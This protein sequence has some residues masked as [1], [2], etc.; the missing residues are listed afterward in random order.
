M[1]MKRTTAIALL[2]GLVPASAFAAA[3]ATLRPG[4]QLAVGSPAELSITIDGDAQPPA[5]PRV[6]GASIQL[7]GQMSQTRMTN[8]QATQQM[9]YVY[10]V[11][12]TRTGPLDIPAITVTTPT[13]AESTEPVHATVTDSPVAPSQA[14]AAPAATA[15]RAV[16]LEPAHAFVTLDVPAKSLVVGQAIPIKIRAYFRGGTSATLQGL[17]HV[18]S[19]AFTLSEL[20]DKPA[21]AQ[22]EI[23]GEPYLQATW[24]AVLSPAKPSNG[25]LGVELPVELA[26][27]AAARPAQH[28]SLRDVFGADPF[29]DSFA[30]PFGGSDPFAGMGDPFG[31][32]DTMFDIG[33]MQQYQTTLRATAG[34]IVVTDLPA[35]GRPASFT[36]AVGHFDVALDPIAGEPRVGEPLTLSIRVTGTGNF[37]R[38]EMTGAADAGDLKTYSIKSAFTP[39]A[40]STLTGTKTFTQTVVPTRAGD[41]TIPALALAYFD[42]AKHA[43][44]TAETKPVTLPIAAARGGGSSD[45]GLAASVRDPAMVPNRIDAGGTRATLL[46]L[47]RQSR[48][49]MALAGLVALTALVVVA[50]WSRKSPRIANVLRSRRIDRAITRASAD[51]DRAARA[52]DRPA[53]F[54]AARTALQTRL[55]ASWDTTPEAITAHDVAT[56]L[57]DRGASIC[58][59]FEQADGVTYG[60]AIT[61]EPLEHW[62]HV[63][64]AELANWKAAS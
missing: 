38:V 48:L 44:V 49:W 52:N 57:G 16:G 45:P 43:Y 59:V 40:T 42:P 63:V 23:R 34:T 11:V 10:T 29:G 58:S 27:R 21:Q 36:G 39:S 56:R 26:Y 46:P 17:P 41:L 50:A 51:M 37:D 32:M 13:G 5:P 14:A 18:T 35:A 25:K 8:G 33:P 54:S 3:H 30:D 60:G 24:T 7:T 61:P 62:H 19:D 2:L 6:D 47:I 53:F 31:D 55:A 28:R 4:P 1:T 22:L 20:S 64:R 15:D 12:P 9:T